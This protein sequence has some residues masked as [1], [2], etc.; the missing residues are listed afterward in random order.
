LIKR[1]YWLEKDFVKSEKYQKS[2]GFT[3]VLNLLSTNLSTDSV[4]IFFFKEYY[5]ILTNNQ[6]KI[7]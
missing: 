5:R 4:N 7:E 3:G 1:K 6:W 2:R